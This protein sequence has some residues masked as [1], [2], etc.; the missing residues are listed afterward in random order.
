MYKMPF[1]LRNA[2]LR[3]YQLMGNDEILLRIPQ[4]SKKFLDVSSVE[5][6]GN[7][8][9]LSTKSYYSNFIR[10]VYKDSWSKVYHKPRAKF[11]TY[12]GANNNLTTIPLRAA[13]K[14]VDVFCKKKLWKCRKCSKFQSVIIS[15]F[16]NVAV[17]VW[18]LKYVFVDSLGFFRNVW[19]NCS[20]NSSE[21]FQTKP[22]KKN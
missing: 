8:F 13:L 5:Y 7:K 3:R 20:C 19:K 22:Y 12:I 21:K 4:S 15:K 14:F 10:Y 18:N 6:C 11:R 17:L 1:K 9:T 2:K 16:F